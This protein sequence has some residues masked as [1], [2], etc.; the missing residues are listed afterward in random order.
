MNI[1]ANKTTRLWDF[2]RSKQDEMT[3]L[4]TALVKVETPS[5]D[6]ASQAAAQDILRGALIDRGYR[7]RRIPGSKS[8]GHL[9]AA[10]KNR[11]SGRPIQ[12]L[13]GH[14]DTVWPI[15]TLEKMPV[16]LNDGKLHGPGIYDMK[17][18]LVQAIFAIEALQAVGEPPAVTPL[19]FINSDEEIGSFESKRYIHRLAPIADRAF[20]M[21]PALGPTGKLKTARRRRSL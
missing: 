17:A 20:V 9:L 7:V 10:P 1:A 13:L 5:H 6:A 4:L 11:I 18:G 12:L 21:E 3:R 8:G 14:C 15:G 16:R 19:M 2:L